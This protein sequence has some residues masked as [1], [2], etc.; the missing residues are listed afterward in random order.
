MIVPGD[1]DLTCAA[2]EGV[3]TCHSAAGLSIWIKWFYFYI[4]LI[5]D[6]QFSYD[7]TKSEVIAVILLVL[8]GC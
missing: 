6:S 2:A 5:L 3:F 8:T 1:H 4:S 7:C